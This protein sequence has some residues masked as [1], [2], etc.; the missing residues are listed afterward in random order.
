MRLEITVNQPITY[1][2]LLRHIKESAKGIARTG[3]AK[4]MEALEGLAGE[5]GFSNYHELEIRA[6]TEKRPTRFKDVAEILA[7]PPRSPIAYSV[8]I[9]DSAWSLRVGKHG[10]LLHLDYRPISDHCDER[11]E[12]DIGRYHVLESPK[13]SRPSIRL[14]VAEAPMDAWVISRWG[15]YPQ[16]TLDFM[17]EVEVKTLSYHFG[18]PFDYEVLGLYQQNI[19][20]MRFFKSP[21]FAALRLALR[22]ARTPLPDLRAWQGGTCYLWAHLVALSDTNFK[23]INEIVDGYFKYEYWNLK[24]TYRETAQAIE[25]LWHQIPTLG[26]SGEGLD[27][28]FLNVIESWEANNRP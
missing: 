2:E 11:N 10:P 13:N 23:R 4:H 12:S 1:S 24:G 6:A 9:G 25:G 20:E 19:S 14:A 26:D 17:N 3:A 16:H 18:I 22:A 27:Y 8:R 28:G 7:C 5:H 21:A 15:S